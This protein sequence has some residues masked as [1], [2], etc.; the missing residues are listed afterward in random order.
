MNVYYMIYSYEL[1][2]EVYLFSQKEDLMHEWIDA[3]LR[4]GKYTS[5]QAAK[6]FKDGFAEWHDVELRWGCDNV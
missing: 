5:D 1:I 6:S 2:P 3:C 4:D